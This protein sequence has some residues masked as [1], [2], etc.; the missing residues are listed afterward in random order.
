MK[1]RGFRS[2]T[3]E[4]TSFCDVTPCRLVKSATFRKMANSWFSKSS[5]RRTLVMGGLEELWYSETSVTIY[6][7]TWRITSQYSRPPDMAPARFVA[8]RLVW[9]WIEVL[10]KQRISVRT[11]WWALTAALYRGEGAPNCRLIAYILTDRAPRR[12]CVPAFI[13]PCE[14]VSHVVNSIPVR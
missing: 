2:D 5:S 12:L 14:K 6:Q 11:L 8:V 10:H 9:L 4:D 1:I 7:T 13:E 3:D